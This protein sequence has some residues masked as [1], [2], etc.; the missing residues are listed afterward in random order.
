[1]VDIAHTFGSQAD[2][3]RQAAQKFRLPYFDYYRPRSQSYTTFPGVSD[4]GTTSFPYDFSMPQVLTVEKV[5][6][7]KPGAT[8]LSLEDN[9]LNFFAFPRS[10]SIPES[11][12]QVIGQTSGGFSRSRTTRYPTDQSPLEGDPG[13]M[14]LAL[15]KNRESGTGQ[16]LNMIKDPSY[17]LWDAF[18]TDTA[19]LT[20]TSGSLED[21]HGNYHVL[22]GDTFGHMSQVPVAAFDPVFWFHHW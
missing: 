20:P 18:S 10:G 8:A 21:I 9:P 2:K 5:M 16:S 15:N 13:A 19:G 6:L 17:D 22:I 4:D 7:M 3:Y 11:Q 12:W 1:M 14:N